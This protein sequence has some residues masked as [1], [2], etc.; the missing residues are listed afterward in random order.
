MASKIVIK[1]Y[2]VGS[3]IDQIGCKTI[4]RGLHVQTSEEVFITVISVRPGRAQNLLQKRAEQSKKLLLSTIT[5]A[6]DFGPLPQD[7]F[8]YTH[9]LIPSLPIVQYLDQIPD[10]E[11]CNKLRADGR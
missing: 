1:G 10:A 5:S 6:M 11:V 7:R 9:K 2:Q 3:R 8:F 4:Y